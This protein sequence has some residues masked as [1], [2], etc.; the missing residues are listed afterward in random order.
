MPAAR[1]EALLDALARGDTGTVLRALGDLGFRD[2]PRSLRN[3]QGLLERLPGSRLAEVLAA[4]AGAP[5]PDLALNNFER[6]LQALPAPTPAG[7]LTDPGLLQALATACGASPFLTRLLVAAPE[8]LTWLGPEGGLRL[9]QD[10]DALLVALRSQVGS[11]PEFVELG[12]GLRSFK[13][14]EVLR[15]A[16]RDLAGLA[17][18]EETAQALSDLAAAALQVA[19]EGSLALLIR[20]HGWPFYHDEQGALQPCEFVV[21][22]LGKLGG[23]ELNFSSDIDL[24]YLYTSDAGETDGVPDGQGAAT[25]RLSLHAFFVKLAEWITRALGEVTDK[26]FVFRVDVGLRPEGIYGALA[27]SLRGAEL[28]YESWGQAWERAALVKARPVAGSLA[29]GETFIRAITP[30][31]YR[32]YFDYTA[33]EEIKEMKVRIGQAL[34][35]SQAGRM[36]LKLMEGGIREIEFFV[37]ALQLIYGGKHPD[38]RVPGTLP[39]LAALQARGLVSEEE[40]RALREAYVFL[41]TLEHR[42]QVVHER[43]THTL[44]EAPEEIRRV[45]RSA[46]YR[47]GARA[48]DAF[49]TDLRQHTGRVQEIYRRL[50]YEPAEAIQ[51]GTVP[52]AEQLL[53]DAANDPATAASRLRT[54]GFKDPEAAARHLLRLT[55]GPPRSHVSPKSRRLLRRIAPALLSEILGVPSPDQALA[56]LEQFLNRVG[57]RSTYYALLAENPPTLRLLIRLFGSAT[58]LANFFIR[59]PELLD[60]LVSP[61][62]GPL[63]KGREAMLKELRDAVAVCETFEEQLDALRRY[64][65]AEFVRIGT[66]DIYG[67]LG[68]DA[69]MTQL[70]DLAEACLQVTVE[71]CREE[72][73]P[74]YGLPQATGR[75]GAQEASLA[76]LGLGRLG[77]REMT[78]HSDLD[79]IFVYTPE[80]ETTGGRQ[81]L[82]NQ[83]YFAR[84]AARILSALGTS[85]RE[86]YAYRMDTRLRPSGTVGPLVTSLAGFEAYHRTSSQIWERQA[87]T[88]ARC[89]VGAPALQAQVAALVQ[90]FVYGQPW[91]ER[92][93]AEMARLRQRMETELAREGGGRRDVKL[94]RGGLVDVEF[95]VQLLQ[96]RHGGTHPAV[97]VPHTGQA[98]TALA[99]V[100]VLGADE[101]QTLWE[102]YRF[103]GELEN[104]LRLV[105]DRAIH[106][107]EEDPGKLG[108]VARYRYPELPAEQGGARLLEE[109]RARTEAVKALFWRYFPR[110]RPPRRRA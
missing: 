30:F 76:I 89:V 47:D 1:C 11:A 40:A 92:I 107:L 103:L 31:V 56:H 55:Q 105:H 83:E 13:Q 7:L 106:E 8:H 21:L 104:R 29:L 2:G 27:N 48:L 37:Q 93:P 90:E 74:R 61:E 58:Y 36:N 72:L 26:G 63:E 91:S 84:L 53:E 43:Q 85:T 94:G 16:L 42:V 98:L 51:A 99:Q 73:R 108:A 78:Y 109:Y 60:A 22:G 86:G 41:R 49:W 54:L 95:L 5:D 66:N 65:N 88:R 32:R 17:S 81:R 46:G 87:L 28:Y 10:G 57:A 18:L 80:G 79:I 59:H 39:A 64:R 97:R 77:S 68:L 24:Q 96:L 70:S 62:S 71:C 102:A 6:L 23:R 110:P 12:A 44:P 100:G 3:L 9:R 52:E 69:V 19:Y 50:F 25:G 34:A 101:Y 45:A 38:L 82:T 20:E 75:D 14:R 35:R 15:I 67:A 4:C 33:I